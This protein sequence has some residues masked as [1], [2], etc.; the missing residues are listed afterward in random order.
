MNLERWVKV[1]AIVTGV[2]SLISVAVALLQLHYDLAKQETREWQQTA[3]FSIISHAPVTGITEKE[4]QSEYNARARDAF[5]ELPREELTTSALERTLLG[6]IATHAI[7]QL[8]NGSFAFTSG[9]P[10]LP[11]MECNQVSG[12]FLI[13]YLLRHPGEDTAAGLEQHLKTAHL[14]ELTE[15]E[16]G[17]L[18][19]MMTRAGA[20]TQKDGKYLPGVSVFEQIPPPGASVPPGRLKKP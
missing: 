12:D 10:V 4:I 2:V 3:V 20:I 15:D 19:H 6:V 5:K 14:C 9:P 8:S 13:Q 18:I 16:F 7:Q 1:C 17:S 11:D